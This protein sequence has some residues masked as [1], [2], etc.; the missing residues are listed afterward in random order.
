[1]FRFVQVS[2]QAT[3]P[4]SHVTTHLPDTHGC[5]RRQLFPHTPQLAGSRC[6]S[7][8]VPLHRVMPGAQVHEPP[9]QACPIGQVFPQ[10]PQLEGSMFVLVQVSPQAVVPIGQIGPVGASLPSSLLLLSPTLLASP[11]SC[12]DVSPASTEGPTSE[13]A[14]NSSI[15]ASRRCRML[16]PAVAMAHTIS[17]QIVVTTCLPCLQFM[18]ALSRKSERRASQVVRWNCCT[19]LLTDYVLETTC[20][21]ENASRHGIVDGIGACRPPAVAIDVECMQARAR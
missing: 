16:H 21:T 9:M 18:K 20:R 14:S 7:V 8:Q 19:V 11:E 6:T 1:M 13:K 15:P 5:P 17:N 10:R 2:P 4:I 12:M 3:A